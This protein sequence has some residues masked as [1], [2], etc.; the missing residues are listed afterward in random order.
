MNAQAFASKS[1]LDR[2]TQFAAQT[3]VGGFTYNHM[4]ENTVEIQLST[5]LRNMLQVL[6]INS[7]L[8]KNYWQ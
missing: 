4:K 5:I 3:V 1:F 7:K 6:Q 2:A 8:L